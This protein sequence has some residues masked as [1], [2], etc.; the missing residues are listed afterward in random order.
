MASRNNPKLPLALRGYSRGPT[1]RL[2]RS[3][4]EEYED[5]WQHTM[6]LRERLAATEQEQRAGD[7][8]ASAE[9]FARDVRRSAKKQAKLTLRRAEAQSERLLDESVARHRDLLDACATLERHHSHLLAEIGDLREEAARLATQLDSV[10]DETLARAMA[11]LA[12]LD[13]RRVHA[14]APGREG[15]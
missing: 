9:R 11:T 1:D 4:T 14:D 6:A 10:L 12:E 15:S 13:S 5:L 8:V 3:L 7:V 2:L